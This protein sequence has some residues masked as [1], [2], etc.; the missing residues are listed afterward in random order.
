M[1]EHYTGLSFDY[2]IS[3]NKDSYEST[4]D[5][6][7]NKV[8]FSSSEEADAYIKDNAIYYRDEKIINLNEIRVKGMHNYENIMCAIIATKELGISNETIKEVLNSISLKS[9]VAKLGDKVYLNMN[10][11]GKVNKNS[12]ELELDSTNF[13]NSQI[14]DWSFGK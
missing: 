8:Y 5:I 4:K 2:I 14:L 3:D 13:P 10:Y 12:G 11:T 7:S 1:S 9:N 6:K